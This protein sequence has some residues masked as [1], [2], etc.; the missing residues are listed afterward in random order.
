MHLNKKRSNRFI[1]K[2]AL[3][4]LLITLGQFLGCFATTNCYTARTLAPGKVA[5]T[6]GLDYLALM[7]NEGKVHLNTRSFALPSLGV[8]AGLPFRFETAIRWY[9]IKTFEGA[10]RWQVNPRTFKWFDVSANFHVGTFHLGLLNYL[11]IGFTIDKQL[12]PIIPYL[13]Y[14]R[15]RYNLS[16]NQKEDLFDSNRVLVF[17]VGIPFKSDMIIPEV[18]YFLPAGY[19]EKYMYFSIGVRISVPRVK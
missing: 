9:L 2:L 5:L 15:Y 4:L 18:N 11:K 7:D 1:V 8:A 10:L 17:G 6:P 3:I 14:Y 12:G 13:S 19:R 16:I